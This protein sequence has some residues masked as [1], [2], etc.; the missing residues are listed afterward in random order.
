[1]VLPFLLGETENKRSLGFSA[2]NRFKLFLNGVFQ[3]TEFQRIVVINCKNDIISNLPGI[4]LGVYDILQLI[5]NIK[6]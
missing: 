2:L 4:E 5:L 1:M 3:L 6:K